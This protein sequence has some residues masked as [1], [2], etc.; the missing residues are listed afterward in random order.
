MSYTVATPSEATTVTMYSSIDIG[1][2]WSLLDRRR[3][4]IWLLP[5]RECPHN[6]QSGSDLR[7]STAICM[8]AQS[9]VDRGLVERGYKT[10]Q[11]KEKQ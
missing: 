11:K 1:S 10:M 4:V 2:Q 7:R 8:S 6:H 3:S 5:E 9:V